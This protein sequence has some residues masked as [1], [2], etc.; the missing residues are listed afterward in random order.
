[1]HRLDA[2]VAEYPGDIDLP[3]VRCLENALVGCGD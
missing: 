3:H 1:M 2:V